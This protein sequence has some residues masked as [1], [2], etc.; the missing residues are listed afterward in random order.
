[1]QLLINNVN[2]NKSYLSIEK[3]FIDDCLQ[4]DPKKRLSAKAA[5]EHKVCY[6]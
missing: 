4:K 1:M 5:R 6:F 3:D 2:S